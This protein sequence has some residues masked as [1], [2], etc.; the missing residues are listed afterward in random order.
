MHVKL[1]IRS[2]G[3]SHVA[4]LYSR[5]GTQERLWESETCKDVGTESKHGELL[6]NEDTPSSIRSSHH[7][8]LW[9]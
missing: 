9:P 4:R 5:V 8:A 3:N 2:R 1:V 6:M 7:A